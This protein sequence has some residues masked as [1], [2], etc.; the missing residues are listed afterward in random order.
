MLNLYLCFVFQWLSPPVEICA[1]VTLNLFKFFI[2]FFV[3]QN[4]EILKTPLELNDNQIATWVVQ[5][6]V[7]FAH[8][9][10]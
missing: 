3:L 7:Y 10:F 1:S 4:F 8:F 9:S 6:V 5:Q 2:L